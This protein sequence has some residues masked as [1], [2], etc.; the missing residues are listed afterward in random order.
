MCIRDRLVTA[1]CIAHTEMRNNVAQEDS[2]LVD[3]CRG[4]IDWVIDAAII[5]L[6]QRVRLEPKHEWALP[7]SQEF[8]EILARLPA[9]GHWSTMEVC[10][11]NT[12]L[13]PGLPP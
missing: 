12:R 11:E 6:T 1:Q 2:L 9:E 13:L 8:T 5:A 4:P 10:L 7:L 3:I